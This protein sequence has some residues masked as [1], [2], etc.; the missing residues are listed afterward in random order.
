MKLQSPTATGIYQKCKA[1]ENWGGI[2]RRMK[3]VEKIS[4]L[5]SRLHITVN[6]GNFRENFISR[7]ALKDIFA[8]LK[9]RD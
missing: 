6:F 1:K 3:S 2:Q 7:I 9:I 4:K 8:T 5:I